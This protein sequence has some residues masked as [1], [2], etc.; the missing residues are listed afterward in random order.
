MENLLSG[1]AETAPRPN[2]QNRTIGSGVMEGL[3][4]RWF[5]KIE[6]GRLI[7]E[8]PSG[9]QEVFEGEFPGC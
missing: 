5:K 6:T 1:S 2:L 7:I 3:I 8:F 4:A 9:R